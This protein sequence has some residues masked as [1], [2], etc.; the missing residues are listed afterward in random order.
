VKGPSITPRP[1]QGQPVVTALA[2]G[3]A[4]YRLVG[5]AADVGF[6]TPHDTAQVRDIIAEI[7]AMQAA[8]GRAAE[9]VHVVGD[10][11]VF[12]DGDAASAAARR[13]RL[14]ETAGG[15]DASDALAFTGTPGQLADLLQDWH[16]AGLSGFRLRPAAIPHDLLLITRGLVPELQRRGAFR[17]AYQAGTLRGRLGLPRPANRYALA[18]G[19]HDEHLG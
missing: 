1:P 2:H 7:R 8:A 13:A 6:V 16:R 3:R 9:T 18:G 14:D 5:R 12:L 11:L 4:P 10:L 17:R 19:G 15:A